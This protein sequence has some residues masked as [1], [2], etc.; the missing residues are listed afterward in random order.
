MA[1]RG[2]KSGKVFYGWWVVFASGVGLAMCYGPIVVPTF[3]IFLKPL[4]QE[5]GWSRTQ[6]SL[7]FSLGTLGLALAAPFLGWLVDR[8][9][10]RRVILLAVLLFGLSVLSLSF[11]SIHLWHF[12][13]IYLL[14]GVVGS[15][16][17]LP[18]AKVISRWFDRRRGFALGL[19]VAALALGASITPSLA[20]ALITAVGWRYAY[21]GLGLLAMGVTIPVVGLLL[22]ETPQVMGLRPDG[23]AVGQAEA[24]KPRGP[25]EGL[26][27]HETWH[28]GTFWLMVGAFFLMSVSFYG[29][30]THLVPLLTDRGLSAQS[31]ALTVSLAAGATFVGRLGIGYLLDRF[32]APYVA[33][34]FFCGFALGIFL[35]WSGAV[36]G[37]VF[38]AMVLVGLGLGA[39]LDVMPYVVSRY[40]GLR[41]F[42]EIFGYVSAAFNLGGIV[43]PLLMGAGFDATGS[44]S[45]VLATFGVAALTAAWLMTQLGP[46]RIVEAAAE[47]VVVAGV[48]RA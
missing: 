20:Q 8:F 21:V 45:L 10:A 12:Y 7:A 17:A 5:F 30:I 9:G 23:E 1:T 16:T 33:G 2:Q 37:L 41:A 34:C 4:S 40:F 44:Y 15:G 18:Y 39:E 25:E 6:I 26:S 35:L 46:Y 48:S 38:V 3:G 22:K 43:G 31:A 32:F 29:Y 36:G 11:L 19:S 47:P 42:G 13:A 14:M 28:T 24:S 27:F